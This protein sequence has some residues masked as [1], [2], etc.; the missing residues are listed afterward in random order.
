MTRGRVDEG[1]TRVFYG[2]KGVDSFDIA[3]LNG[4]A[5]PCFGIALCQINPCGLLNLELL[6]SGLSRGWLLELSV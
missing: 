2:V 1:G 4:T 6:G 3:E 5:K